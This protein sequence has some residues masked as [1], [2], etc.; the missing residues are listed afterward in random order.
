LCTI[1]T[2]SSTILGI[3]IS[4]ASAITKEI[5]TQLVIKMKFANRSKQNFLEFVLGFSISYLNVIFIPL[6]NGFIFDKDTLGIPLSSSWIIYF[7]GT[8]ASNIIMN[9]ILPYVVPFI[10]LLKSKCIITKRKA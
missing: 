5:V 1:A 3:V 8:M 6:L 7:C 10:L 4:I 9:A 2:N